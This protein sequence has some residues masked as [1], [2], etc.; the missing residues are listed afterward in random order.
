[1]N[2]D[3]FYQNLMLL[4]EG[5]QHSLETLVSY[6]LICPH[7]GLKPTLNSMEKY[8]IVG[9]KIRKL[10]NDCCHKDTYEMIKTMQVI[11]QDV[12]S[13]EEITANLN[14]KKSIPFISDEVCLTMDE[15]F[16]RNKFVDTAV[17]KYA[18][19]NAAICRPKL[20]KIIEENQSQPE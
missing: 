13:K 16:Q 11:S 4:A 12:Y 5:N 18:K 6:V 10:Y 3:Y 8:G 14:S 1:M 9:D 20:Q 19:L 7:K 17:A 15:N 2:N